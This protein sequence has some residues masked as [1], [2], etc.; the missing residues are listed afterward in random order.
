MTANAEGPQPVQSRLAL[1]LAAGIAEHSIARAEDDI[2]DDLL[3][4]RVLL[5]LRG[6]R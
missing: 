5:D 6:G 3:E 2:G 4:P 1:R